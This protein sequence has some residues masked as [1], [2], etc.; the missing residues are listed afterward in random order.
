MTLPGTDAAT[1]DPAPTDPAPLARTDLP[2][3]LTAGGENAVAVAHGL[4]SDE[5]TLWILRQALKGDSRYSD[6]VRH[7]AIS[8]SVLSSRLARLTRMGLLQR[9]AYLDRPAR[10]EY[11]LTRRG[12]EIWPVLLAIW[13]WEKAWADTQATPLPRMVHRDCGRTFTPAL[14]CAACAATVRPR[15]VSGGL[16]PSGAWN[17]N[18]AQATTRRRSHRAD[19][20]SPGMIPATMAL[21]GNRWSSAMLGAAFLGATRF[22]EFAS[23]MG[24]PPTMVADRLR[25]FRELGV[26]EATP[27]TERPDWVTYHLTEK[28]RAFFPTIM[29]TLDWAQRWFVSPEGPALQIH[30]TACTA[31]LVPRLSCDQCGGVLHGDAIQEVPAP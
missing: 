24:A 3:P 10:H 28:G 2:T 8:N 15:D 20:S 9:S 12:R 27:H 1:T 16:G 4:V 6:F 21:I 23:R 25:T 17:R 14:T 18:V 30:H 13:A 11:R 7:G 26:L 19:D 22:S 29:C 5:W 31:L